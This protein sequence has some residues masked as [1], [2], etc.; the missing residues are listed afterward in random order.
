MTLNMGSKTLESHFNSFCDWLGSGRKQN[1][2]QD[3]TPVKS[4]IEKNKENSDLNELSQLDVSLKTF[5]VI[6]NETPNDKLDSY[7]C[8]QI[9]DDSSVIIYDVTPAKFRFTSENEGE[10]GDEDGKIFPLL[11]FLTSYRHHS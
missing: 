6:T 10:D 7:I 4:T 9:V 1:D 11:L 8:K 3:E 2:Y 5:R